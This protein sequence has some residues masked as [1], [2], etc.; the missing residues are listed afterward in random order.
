M[1]LHRECNE[2]SMTQVDGRVTVSYREGGMVVEATKFS[3]SQL[4]SK[5]ESD[6]F[7][8]L[9]NMLMTLRLGLVLRGCDS[10][11]CGHV[12][13]GIFGNLTAQKLTSI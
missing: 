4:R 13:C 7:H 11:S 1:Q 10:T 5:N 2:L 8:F 3:F 9:C 12:V 6:A